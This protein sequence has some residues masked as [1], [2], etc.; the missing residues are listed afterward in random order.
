MYKTKSLNSR[1]LNQCQ[2]KNE[3]N[4][5]EIEDRLRDIKTNSKD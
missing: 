1:A 4:K 3:R 5:T 2:S